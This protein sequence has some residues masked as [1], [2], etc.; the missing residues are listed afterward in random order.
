[1]FG[2][3]WGEHQ[4]LKKTT[5]LL[6]AAEVLFA[7]VGLV[8]KSL[9]AAAEKQLHHFRRHGNTRLTMNRVEHL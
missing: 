7:V 6:L 3:T 4:K 8:L 5:H 2:E 1:M 9:L